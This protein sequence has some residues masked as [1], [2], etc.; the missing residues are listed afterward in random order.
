MEFDAV[1]AHTL[2]SHLEDPR[3]VLTEIVRVL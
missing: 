2:F 3:S 1:V